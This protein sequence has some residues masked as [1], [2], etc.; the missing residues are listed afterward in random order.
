MKTAV[1]AALML[2]ASSTVLCAKQPSRHADPDVLLSLLQQKLSSGVD[3]HAPGG[4]VIDVHHPER[5]ISK[6][7]HYMD[8]WY[9]GWEYNSG[10][11]VFYVYD[12]N[13][14]LWDN[15]NDYLLAPALAI[16]CVN[17]NRIGYYVVGSPAN[18]TYNKTE[19]FTYQ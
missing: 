17:G 18:F 6:G 15:I 16:P 2:A 7:W 19:S 3:F 10:S 4:I 14:V 8:A 11:P 12:G 9:C 13:T 1:F 5:P